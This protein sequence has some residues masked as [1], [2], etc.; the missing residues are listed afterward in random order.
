MTTPI[1]S[2]FDDVDNPVIEDED[3]RKNTPDMP[4]F[5]DW[6][7]LPQEEKDALK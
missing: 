5:A 2:L 4:A 6:Q 1:E 7:K 3:V